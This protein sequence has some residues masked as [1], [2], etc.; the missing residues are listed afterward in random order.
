[1]VSIGYTLLC[2][3]RSP[4]DLVR[5]AVAA[6]HAGFDFLAI[7]DHYHPWVEAQGH[8]PNAWATLGA[9]AQ[10]TERIPLMSMVTA[11]TIRYH[12][13]IV[14]Q[15]AAT[16]A[17]LSGERFTLGLGA[18]EQL[19]EHVV[20]HGFPPVRTRHQLLA[21]AVEVIRELLHGGY[22]THHGKRYT[23]DDAKVFDRPEQ[24]VPLGIA[25]SGAASCRLA[26]RLAD[27]AIATEP[28]AALVGGFAAAGGAGKPFYGRLPTC[29]GPDE[30][31]SLALAHEQFAW[32][33]LGWK[34]KA[35]LPNTRNFEAATAYVRPDDVASQVPC[36]PSVEPIVAGVR[37]YAEAGFTHL[38]LLQVGP[39][40]EAFCDFYADQLGQA[41]RSV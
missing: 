38:A 37:A 2:E 16:V 18:G 13:A 7:S 26:G 29:W 4:T 19:N 33:S 5:D 22:V 17:L 36:G 20:G 35:E 25:V 21:E 9:V 15:Q 39:E 8:S 14:A 40:Q 6:E 24:P 1:M 30:A 34:V 11:P 27:L 31:K 3:Q 41:L 23:V 32:A 12:P 28:K 10:A